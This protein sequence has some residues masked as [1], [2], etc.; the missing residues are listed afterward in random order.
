MAGVPGGGGGFLKAEV[1]IMK[2]EENHNLLRGLVS[3]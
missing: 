1:R 3:F 2:D